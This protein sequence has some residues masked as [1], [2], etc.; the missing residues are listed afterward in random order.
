MRF[1]YA[2]KKLRFLVIKNKGEKIMKNKNKWVSCKLSDELRENLDRVHMEL[3]RM[4][5]VGVSKSYALQT[6]IEMGID[7]F[8]ENK[9]VRN[10]IRAF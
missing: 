5:R 1:Q 3:N 8:D 2:G 9:G 10:E 6:L 4:L 7:A